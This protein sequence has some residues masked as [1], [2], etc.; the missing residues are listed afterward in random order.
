M[1]ISAE[2]FQ[3]KKIN[4]QTNILTFNSTS[5]R[6]LNDAAMNGVY[7]AFLPEA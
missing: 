1:G 4:K 5:I 2:Y 6:R 3:R 7:V